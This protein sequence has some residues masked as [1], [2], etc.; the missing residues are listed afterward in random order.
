MIV[1]TFVGRNFL[2]LHVSKA[3]I[4]CHGFPYERGSVIDKGYGEIAELFSGIEPTIVFDFSGCGNSKGYFSIRNW[5]ED[6]ERIARKFRRV[7]I[8]GYSMGALVAMKTAPFLRNLEKLILVAPPLPEIFEISRLKEMHSHALEIIRIGSFEE[9]SKE[10]I[11]LQ[12][13]DLLKPLRNLNSEKLVVHGTK[14]EIVPYECGL[15]VFK[16]LNEPK[17][18]LKVVNGD[19]FL[20]R[21]ERVMQK[22]LSWFK[23][24]IKDREIEI[25]V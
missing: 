16:A 8:L 13:E 23:G 12:S 18:F 14:D 4:I 19:H 11:E 5:V 3:M 10:V 20:R 2:R 7:S 21:N 25:T 17:S 15:K 1:D 6:L 24:E 9:F 22:V